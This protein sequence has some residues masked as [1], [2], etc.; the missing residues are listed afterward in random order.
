MKM[1]GNKSI[2][3]SDRS[4][5][6][7]PRRSQTTVRK[8]KAAIL[9]LILRTLGHQLPEKVDV[10]PSSG[11]REKQG[12][13]PGNPDHSG[14]PAGLQLPRQLVRKAVSQVLP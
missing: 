9:F 6:S 12:R 2:P 4:P 11:G 8:T 14:S 10:L 7:R 3:S 5:S 1:R 13:Q